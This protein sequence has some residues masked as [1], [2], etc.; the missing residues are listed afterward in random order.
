MLPKNST[1]ASTQRTRSLISK[2]GFSLVEILVVIGIIAALMGFLVPKIA[3]AAGKAERELAAAAQIGTLSS[4]IEEFYTEYGDF[5]QSWTEKADNDTPHVTLRSSAEVM[6]PLL[7]STDSGENRRDI[8]FF[9]ADDFKKNK[10]GLVSKSA[11]RLLLSPWANDENDLEHLYVIRIDTDYDEAIEDLIDKK[12]TVR[13]RRV[14]IMA[15]G[16]DRKLGLDEPADRLDNAT[17]Y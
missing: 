16:E 2:P 13:G 12:K 7:G 14:L 8:A 17:S 4:A 5:P 11:G 1:Q 15:A 9:E 6:A 3:G 10:G